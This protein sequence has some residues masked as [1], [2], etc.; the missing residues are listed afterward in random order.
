MTT[1]AKAG[2]S[3]AEVVRAVIDLAIQGTM[4]DEATR[5]GLAGRVT[6]L[7]ADPTYVRHPLRPDLPPLVH[8]ED[9]VRHAQAVRRPDMPQPDDFRAVDVVTHAT[10]DP[11]VVVTEFRYESTVNGTAIIAPCIWVTRVRDGRIVEARDYNGDPHPRQPVV[12][13]TR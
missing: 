6:E 7:Y 9:F 5:N 12:T 3:P 11:E 10:T 2:D 1:P 4:G 8:H 13:G